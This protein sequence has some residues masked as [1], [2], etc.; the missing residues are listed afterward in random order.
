MGF[1]FPRYLNI[2]DE[3]GVVTLLYSLPFPLPMRYQPRN[4]SQGETVS[5]EPT[6][7][8]AKASPSVEGGTHTSADPNP[9]AKNMEL[10]LFITASLRKGEK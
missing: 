3:T 2:G 8:A 7:D 6:H 5:D 9:N 1:Q 4:R 10:A